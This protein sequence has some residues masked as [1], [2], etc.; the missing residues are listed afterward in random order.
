MKIYIGMCK[1]FFQT[2][3]KRVFDFPL[4]IYIAE[5]PLDIYKYS[6]RVRTFRVNRQ[7]IKMKKWWKKKNLNDNLRNASNSI[8]YWISGLAPL[9]KIRWWSVRAAVKQKWL[10]ISQQTTKDGEKKNEKKKNKIK[11]LKK[12]RVERGFSYTKI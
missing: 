10:M 12:W 1:T 9:V 4:F 11:V 6:D 3:V 8:L 7:E 2:Q 5:N